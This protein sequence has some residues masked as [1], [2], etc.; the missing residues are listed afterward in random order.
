MDKS[1]AGEVIAL[2]RYFHRRPELSWHEKNTQ[3]KITEVLDSLD[4]PWVAAA[5]TG[6]IA[7]IEGKGAGKEALTADGESAGQRAEEGPGAGRKI[8]GIRADMDAL[9]VT[10]LSGCEF[11]SENEG[12][13]HACGHDCHIAI[14]LG[15]AMRLAQMRNELPVTV[16]LIFQPSE[17]FVEDSG[18]RYIAKEELVKSCDRLIGLHIWSKIEAGY[19]SLRYGAV[20]AATDTFDIEI[21]GKGGHGGMP[22]QAIDPL[23]AGVTF[24]NEVNRVVSREIHPLEPHVISVTAFN[25]GTTWNVVPDNAHLK[26]TARAFSPEVRDAIPV[27]LE[28]LAKGVGEATRTEITVDYHFGPPPT[29]ND[30]AAV[31]TGLTAAARVFGEDRVIPFEPQMIGEDFAVYPN[32]KCF[33]L[34]GGGFAE[35]QK[36]WPQ[37]SPYFAIDERALALGV[38]Y[39]VEYVKTY[40]EETRRAE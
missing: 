9:P 25:A 3:K 29:V 17:E 2:R 28:R 13:S 4:I 22:H 10:E 24:V 19:A 34:L 12:V 36:R 26:G 6:V 35:E 11:A 30:D 37:H 33:M 27:A 8:I 1:I 5:G 16:R 7:T 14:L 18:A 32:E 39:F 21:T 23:A 31:K 38:D 15:T 20:T 40:A